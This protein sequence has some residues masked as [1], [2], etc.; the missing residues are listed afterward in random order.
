VEKIEADDACSIDSYEGYKKWQKTQN[1][2]DKLV[3]AF[4]DKDYFQ[5]PGHLWHC[6]SGTMHSYGEGFGWLAWDAEKKKVSGRGRMWLY[7]QVMCGDDADNYFANSANLS[8]KWADKS[9]FDILKDAKN[10]KEALEALVKGYKLLYPSP[11][12]IVGWRGYEDPKDM[13]ILKPDAD[14]FK[15]EVDWAYVLQ[16]NFTLA[17]MLRS[18]DEKPV[19]VKD[20]L[21]KLE[22][23]H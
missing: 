14:D 21:T 23:E 16:E 5:V 7:F 2:S 17:R 9:A 8:M 12:T 13:K 10:D 15:I 11:K 6:D 22:V 3:L 20:V 4:T 18:R 19:V 1:D